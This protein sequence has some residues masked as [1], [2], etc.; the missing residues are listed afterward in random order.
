MQRIT[1]SDIERAQKA[2]AQMPATVDPEVTKFEAIKMLAHVIT[3]MRKRGHKLEL[4]A[5]F[6]NQ[7]QI[8]ISV[9]TL[10]TY[11]YRVKRDRARAAEKSPDHARQQHVNRPK[12]GAVTPATT[13]SAQTPRSP[14]L[15]P[16]DPRFF[17]REDT[18]EI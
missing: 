12:P 10:K 11:L 16:I 17:P 4:V 14:A 15:K 3:R 6:L 8:S 13:T 5:S 9:G 18:E 1:K 7:Q 2:L